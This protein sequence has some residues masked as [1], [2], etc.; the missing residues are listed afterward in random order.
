MGAVFVDPGFESYA[1]ASGRFVRPCVGPWA[2]V[3][4]SSVVEP[5]AAPTSL[6]TFSTW[7]ATLAAFE[8]EQYACTYAGA[9]VLSQSVSFSAAGTYTI[10]VQAYAPSGTVTFP[11]ESPKTMVSGAF[12]FRVD[13]VSVGPAFTVPAASEW[14]LY[15]TVFT[16]S[17][18]GAHTL[19]I[20]N[21]L[22][23]SYFINYDAFCVEE[24][25]APGVCGALG[26]GGLSALRR[27]RR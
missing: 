17:S 6:G 2:F 19:G 10:G 16:V 26:V 9:D 24:V 12:V 22:A 1:V 3:N 11:G 15:S 27:R 5:F 20:A 13:G 18:A 23:A 4:D 8:G 14:T 21:T 7:S 25:P